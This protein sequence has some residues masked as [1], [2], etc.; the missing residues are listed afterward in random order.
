MTLLRLVLQ[1][2]CKDTV[3]EAASGNEGL[4]QAQAMLPDLIIIEMALPESSGPEI[5][6]RLKAVPVLQRIPIL[7]IGAS[8]N[9]WGTYGLSAEG[10]LIKPFGP[11]ELEK[12]RSEL[13]K[14]KTYWLPPYDPWLL[15]DQSK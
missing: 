13:L 15:F 6:R 4:A 2:A 3:I 11:D 12:A 9:Y 5:C 1:K 8:Q 10:F 7:F 14:G